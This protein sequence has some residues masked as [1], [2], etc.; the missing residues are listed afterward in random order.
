MFILFLFFLTLLCS[1]R[2]F[3]CSQCWGW[4]C[5]LICICWACISEW[6]CHF[7]THRSTQPTLTGFSR[8]PSGPSNS[9]TTSRIS[10]ALSLSSRA[11]RRQYPRKWITLNA[12]YVFPF[13]WHNMWQTCLLWF[14]F[15]SL[16]RTSQQTWL[17][18]VALRVLHHGMQ[19][20]S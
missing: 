16:T 1:L 14:F 8:E 5:G 11:L 12:C 4:R 10:R 3:Y 6:L 15:C 9:H 20:R 13:F 7:R 2:L 17:I 18:C 19:L